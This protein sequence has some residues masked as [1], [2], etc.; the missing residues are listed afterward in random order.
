MVVR[1][2]QRDGYYVIEW[3]RPVHFGL[4]DL[5]R[6]VPELV[7]DRYAVNTSFDSGVLSLGEEERLTG[8]HSTERFAHSPKITSP[9][10]IPHDG[11]EEWL[12][13]EQP[14]LLSEY[15]CMVNHGSFTPTH[16]SWTE[17][18][19]LFWSQISRLRP[20]HVAGENDY[21]YLLTRDLALFEKAKNA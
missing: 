6:R 7:L 10:E 12:I 14:T 16:F 19:E 4:F 21:V 17:K 15:E 2:A 20:L 9:S 8:W 11:Y 1:H 13:F 5:F 3:W 18:R